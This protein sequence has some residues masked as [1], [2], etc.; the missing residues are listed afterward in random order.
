VS[1]LSRLR[2]VRWRRV[3]LIGGGGGFLTLLALFVIGYVVTDVPTPNKIATAQATVFLY[4]DGSEMARTGASNRVIVPLT[5]VSDPAQKAILAAEDRGFYTEPGISPKGI[6]RALF[7]NVKGGGVSQG[8]STITQQYAKNAF[9]TQ[10]RTFRR[11]IKE[12][13]ISLKISR[14]VSKD[15]VL[16][17]YLNTIYFGRG[18]NGIETASRTYFGVSAKNLT[19]A[20]AA[21]LA[22]SIRSPAAYDPTR[23]PEM[24][25]ARWDYVLDGM[26]KQGWLSPADRAAARYPKVS[27]V[28]STGG[29]NDRSGPKGYIID[30]VV[31]E[32]EAQGL[33]EGGLKVTTTLNRKAQDAAVKAVTDAV[34]DAKTNH[35]PI[36]ALVSVQPGTGAVVAYVGG[37]AGNGGTDYAG[38]DTRQPGSSFKPYTLAT[39]LSQGKG[40]GTMVDGSSPQDFGGQP[41]RNDEGDG[42]L[43]MIDLVTA[44]RLSVNTAYYHLAQDVGPD[45]VAATAHSAGIPE[46]VTLGEASNGKPGLGITLGVYEVHVIDQAAGYATFAARGTRARPYFVAKVVQQNGGKTLYKAEK[47]TAKAFSEGVAADATY[48]M[49]QVVNDGTGTRA[50]LDGRPTAG[51][52]GTTTDNK[53]A[54]FCGFTPQL[55]TAVLV[56]RPDRKSLA[57]ALGSRGGI[58]GGQVPAQIFKAYMDAALQGQPVEQFPPRA[59]VGQSVTETPSATP[60]PSPTATPSPTPTPSLTPSPTVV[61]TTAPPSAPPSV[62]PTRSPSPVLTTPP[63]TGS[64]SAAPAA[65][66]SP[67]GAPG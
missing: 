14:T 24:A 28:G 13:F 17:D 3:L 18:A 51:K 64:P 53:E 42:P 60:S 61:P 15:Q 21:V 37:T 63:A 35:D 32:L 59:N 30:K 9:L 62:P 44:T 31:D 22:S 45:A 54:W 29:V 46:D 58:Y 67:G 56:A 57:G 23:H 7:A 1:R 27:K 39:A 20:Q 52:T 34:P 12:V 43:G 66:A 36:G 8:G 48:A 11:K 5:Q 40:L 26:V 25:R 33:N 2:Q 6:A 47:D 16:E 4:A 41:V 38:G 50:K 55:A 49:Q 65:S 19:P 10:D